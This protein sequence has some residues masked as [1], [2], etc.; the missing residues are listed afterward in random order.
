MR[1]ARTGGSRLIHTLSNF[2]VGRR[3]G[4]KLA[5]SAGIGV[6]L[7][8]GMLINQLFTTNLVADRYD[9]VGR[10][11]LTVEDATTAGMAIR[12]MQI[13]YRDIQLARSTEAVDKALNNLRTNWQISAKHLEAAAQR[14]VNP[15]NRT[16]LQ[17]LSAIMD[18][19]VVAMG[20]ISDAQKQ[21]LHTGPA[22]TAIA[23]AWT[24]PFEELMKSPALAGLANRPAVEA[25]IL[26]AHLNFFDVRVAAWRWAAQQDPQLIPRINGS[27]GKTMTA[28]QNARKLT[29]D[30]GVLD[31]VDRLEKVA[32]PFQGL[33]ESAARAVKTMAD[34][35]SVI[36]KTRTDRF[37]LIQTAQAVAKEIAEQRMAEAAVGMSQATRVGVAIG[38][39]VIAVLVGSAFFGH[40]AIAVPIRRVGEVLTELSNGNKAVEIPYTRRG[41]EVGAA[42][43][44]ADDFRNKL[45]RMEALEAEQRD[46]EHR[47]AEEKRAAD[48]R[49]AE[50]RRAAEEQQEAATKAAMHQL[51]TNFQTAI[52]GVIETVASAATEL[53]ASASTLTGAAAATQER[54]NA[55]AAASEEASANVQSVASAAEQLTSSV[56]EISKQVQASSDIAHKA[57]AQAQRTDARVNELSQAASRIGD[58]VK[59]ISAVAEQTNLLALNATIEAA[60]AGEAGK[61]FAVVAQEVK[62]LAAQTAKATGDIGA[63]ITHMQSATQD[64]VKDIKEIGSTIGRIS[65]IA[66]AIASAVEEQGAATQEIARNVEQA[67][68][69]TTEVSANI[70][71]V[72]HHASETGAASAQM[73]GSAQS[74]SVEGNRLKREMEDF[75]ESIRTGVGNRRKRDDPNFPGPNRRAGR[76]E[77]AA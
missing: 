20:K 66:A 34:E 31:F 17:R 74:L 53:E 22:R 24:K 64:S 48:E 44:A 45:V 72:S 77:R 56:D 16:R 54:A 70:T 33:V 75:L 69:G 40:F 27:I 52:G 60:R 61:G 28:L 41:D 47:L 8:I 1:A 26:D 21:L 42:A 73:L 10:Q 29:G 57:V 63:Q 12:S 19:Y 11:Q 35:E 15:D 59:M 38:L 50:Q 37:E 23:V 36:A 39:F 13:A 65:E 18:D 55:V 46:T 71:E 14:A 30:N 51:M 68:R 6:L 5:M 43:R 25:A 67:A 49:A 7:V 58:V 62:A 3:I 9:T 32:G 2:F 4:T 76:A